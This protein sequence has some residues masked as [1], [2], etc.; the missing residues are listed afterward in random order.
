M[1]GSEFLEA[2]GEKGT[3]SYAVQSG[4]WVLLVDGTDRGGA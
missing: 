3:E 4:K 2:M 1:K